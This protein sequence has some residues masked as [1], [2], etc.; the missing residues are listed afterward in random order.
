[1]DWCALALD[2]P[3]TPHIETGPG[4]GRMICH[5]EAE[6]AWSLRISKLA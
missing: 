1:M 4:V 3:L 5:D 6:A 2:T